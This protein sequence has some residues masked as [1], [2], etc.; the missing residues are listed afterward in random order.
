[1]GRISN[2][3]AHNESGGLI[4]DPTEVALCEA[5]EQAGYD[6]QV[7]YASTPRVEEI[8]FD[9]ERRCMTTLHKTSTSNKEEILAFTKG[10]LEAVLSRCTRELS[11]EDSL[12]FTVQTKQVILERA[13]RLA[14]D[15]LRVLAMLPQ[16]DL[17]HA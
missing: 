11:S 3:V 7:L 14:A 13:E 15:G 16:A 8:P 1:M 9:A 10:D 6:K 5:A 12:L 4:G 2:D 17:E